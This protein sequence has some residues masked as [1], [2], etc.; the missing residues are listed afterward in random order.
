MA[1]SHKHWG[2]LNEPGTEKLDWH[3]PSQ[4]EINFAIELIDLFHVTSA[5]RLRDLMNS[6]T[7]EGKQLSIELCK[8]IT[9]VKA[10][11][12]GMV[13]LV[14]DDGDSPISKAR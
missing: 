8:S 6:S 9:M 14:E 5:V 1:E 4:E 7:L 12:V 11:V 13:T 10:F 2:Q 3:T